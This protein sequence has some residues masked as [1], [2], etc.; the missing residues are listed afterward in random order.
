M[1]PAL[2]LKTT[3]WLA[4]F[5]ALTCVLSRATAAYAT[6]RPLPF[7]YTTETLAQGET[8]IEQIA[9]LVPVRTL[10]ANGAPIWYMATQFQTEI[11]YGLTDRLEV[12][13]YFTFAPAPNDGTASVPLTEG[14]GVKQR[15]RYA[16]APPGEW[17]I[18]LGFYGEITETD[19]EVELEAKI[20][21]QRRLGRLRIDANLWAEYEL[22]YIPRRDIVL[23]PTLGATVEISPKFHLGLEGSMRVEYPNPAPPARTFSLGPAG[24]L[25]PTLLI[26]FGRMWWST[27]VYARL[28]DID[29]TMQVGEP[30]GPIWARTI[31]G[32]NL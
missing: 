26:N 23:N 13:L 4:A 17:P 22:Y 7:T 20:L 5:A 3:S 27:G 19:Q 1:Q 21:L 12:A 8:E 18:N 6:P 11:E 31:V 15:L 2:G 29:H 14:T 9:D 32:F 10:S 28:T 30:Y 16:F 24:Y 25:G